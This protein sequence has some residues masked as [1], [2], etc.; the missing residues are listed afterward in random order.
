MTTFSKFASSVVLATFTLAAA[1]VLANEPAAAPAAPAAHCQTGMFA[2][3]KT[4]L[5]E[6]DA[7]GVSRLVRWGIGVGG[8]TAMVGTTVTLG[9]IATAVVMVP[10]CT[11]SPAACRAALVSPLARVPGMGG[12]V[13]TLAPG[14]GAAAR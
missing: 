12:V 10:Q 11:S 8:A 3:V 6:K 2:K 5:L 13:E 4:F 7:N 14:A 1:P 9:S